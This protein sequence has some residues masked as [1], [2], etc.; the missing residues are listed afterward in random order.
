VGVGGTGGSV[1][2]GG[3]GGSQGTG[4]AGGSA[5]GSDGGTTDAS[6]R[7]DAGP[8][9]DANSDGYAPVDAAADAD[10]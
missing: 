4:G 10:Y 7:V 1:G 6:T 3:T 5:P 8:R 2:V 9:V